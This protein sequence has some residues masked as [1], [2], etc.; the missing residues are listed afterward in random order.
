M[1]RRPS[2]AIQ[3]CQNRAA[4]CEH[5]AELANNPETK[6]GYLRLAECWHGL[7]RNHE[8]VVRLLRDDKS[9]DVLPGVPC[10]IDF[11]SCS[12]Q[13]NRLALTGQSPL[14]LGNV[15][16]DIATYRFTIAV[17]ADGITEHIR[18]DI[19]WSG[20]WDKITGCQ[21]IDSSARIPESVSPP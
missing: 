21:V 14:A 18:V 6:N 13:N 1:L 2:P 12:S 15:F 7:A 16:D 17:N 11:L 8:F 5:L 10:T 4:E 9:F 3:H 20:R 19:E